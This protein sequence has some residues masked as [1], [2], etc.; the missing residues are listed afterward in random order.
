VTVETDSDMIVEK[1]EEYDE[2]EKKE[3]QEE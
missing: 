3:W 2:K 1:N